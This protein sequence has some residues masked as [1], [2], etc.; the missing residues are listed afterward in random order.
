MNRLSL[1]IGLL[2]LLAAG[3]LDKPLSETSSE[4]PAEG[5]TAPVNAFSKKKPISKDKSLSSFRYF[6]YWH[7]NNYWHD[8][9]S[10]QVVYGHDYTG[11][12]PGE[13]ALCEFNPS[14]GMDGQCIGR[15]G[16]GVNHGGTN[17]CDTSTFS[18]LVYVVLLGD[19]PAHFEATRQ[20]VQQ[21]ADLG[22]KVILDIYRLAGDQI[23][24]FNRFD[25]ELDLK[26]AKPYWDQKLGLL[27]S[28]M[29]GLRHKIF[30]IYTKM[31]PYNPISEERLDG[32]TPKTPHLLP[33]DWLE[34]LVGKVKQHFPVVP[35]F[36][37]FPPWDLRNMDDK[38]CVEGTG[39]SIPQ[40]LDMVFSNPYFEW[41]AYETSKWYPELEIGDFHDVT[42]P[43]FTEYIQKLED[44][45]EQK[46]AGNKPYMFN[47]SNGNWLLPQKRS[48]LEAYVNNLYCANYPDTCDPLSKL[49][50]PIANGMHE[51]ALALP[52]REQYLWYMEWAATH[53]R[54]L[55]TINYIMGDA[56]NTFSCS[57]TNVRFRDQ[58]GGH[59]NDATMKRDIEI[60]EWVL[61]R[62][63]SVQLSEIADGE[64]VQVAYHVAN[65]G[66]SSV[67]DLAL[68][69]IGPDGST[70]VVR[71]ELYLAQGSQLSG[72]FTVPLGSLQT[73]VSHL[74]L[75]LNIA[76][77]T[78]G[79]G[80]SAPLPFLL[81]AS[82]MVSITNA[83]L[84]S[85]QSNAGEL[86]KTILNKVEL[87]VP[88]EQALGGARDG[89]L[90][91]PFEAL[92]SASRSSAPIPAAL[93]QLSDQLAPFR[94]DTP[95][96]REWPGSR[97]G[98][99]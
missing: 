94:I 31:E 17:H 13:G 67:F 71:D 91:A 93:R 84:Q 46:G 87:A 9:L 42:K 12:N 1:L 34:A 29:R 32:R 15:Q 54:A 21:A 70:T 78:L 5:G 6:G 50:E 20:R 88:N 92:F 77:E 98:I 36:M 30:A 62:E 40:Q 3:C 18:N 14:Y 79:V 76:R 49:I 57:A 22:Y 23:G 73:G 86:L 65:P 8:P 10:G 96:P 95:G 89:A 59:T 45:M 19:T 83:K 44:A 43:L 7:A 81:L 47:I 55:G 48:A 97:R 52:T 64:F 74:A 38:D 33:C 37:M 75:R 85:Q 26:S 51:D 27:A 4:E 82:D 60:G 24:P 58:F 25:F 16:V 53:Q 11:L 39:R 61:S 35:T 41:I 72:E 69:L 66:E 63:P 28:T 80:E 68:S 56:Y 2:S 99:E 90:E